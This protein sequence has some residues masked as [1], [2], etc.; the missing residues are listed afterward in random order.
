MVPEAKVI[1]AILD[2][3]IKSLTKEF[4]ANSSHWFYM[5]KDQLQLMDDEQFN[6]TVKMLFDAAIAS[7]EVRSRVNHQTLEQILRG[8]DEL[9]KAV[10][11]ATNTATYKRMAKSVARYLKYLWGS[12]NK[13]AKEIVGFALMAGLDV[14]P[15]NPVPI[16]GH[17]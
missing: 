14:K 12:M 8:F 5:L 2:E 9:A 15:F 13:E 7:G 16:P 1:T 11:E 10:K 4:A 17:N 6:S 3:I